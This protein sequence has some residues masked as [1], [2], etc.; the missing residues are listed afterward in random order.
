[1]RNIVGQS[2]HLE[3]KGTEAGYISANVRYLTLVSIHPVHP[4]AVQ[5]KKFDAKETQGCVEWETFTDR[6]PPVPRGS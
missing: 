1:V 5:R 4:A 2:A 6:P 3:V